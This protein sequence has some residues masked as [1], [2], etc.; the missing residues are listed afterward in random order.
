M[1]LLLTISLNLDPFADDEFFA[2]SGV[3]SVLLFFEQLE[4]DQSRIAIAIN[5][6]I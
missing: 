5:L 1:T 2:G 6:V 3:C 4:M